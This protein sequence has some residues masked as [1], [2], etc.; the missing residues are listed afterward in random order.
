MIWSEGSPNV[1]WKTWTPGSGNSSP[2]AAGGRVFMTT[3]YGSELDDWD[4]TWKQEELHRVVLALDLESGELLWQTPIFFGGKGKVHFRNT[5]A[6]PSPVT[7]GRHVF[8]NFDNILAALD[9]EGN[10]IWKKDVDPDFYLHSHYGVSS[11]PVLIDGAVVLLQDR[12]EGESPDLGWIAAFDKGTGEQIWRDEWDHTCCSYTT[13]LLLERSG[14]G[15][16]LVST[17]S[18]EIIGYDPKTGARLWTAPHGTVQPVPSLVT[19]GDL[20][21]APGGVHERDMIMYRL[22]GH[23]KETAVEPLWK[24][25]KAVPEITTPLLYEGTFFV[26][27]EKGVL[28][29]YDPETGQKKWQ[30]RAPRGKYWPSMI[31]GDG[32]L[33]ATNENGVVAVIAAR[34]SGFQ[35]VAENAVGEGIAGATPAIAGGCLL[36]RTRNHLYCIEKL[37][38]E[39]PNASTS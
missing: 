1:R 18:K 16:E 6:A 38:Q 23:G 37:R 19:A 17:T 10:V 21:C 12:E 24:T 5:R 28:A 27:T 32:K 35:L 39:E 4:L 13:P 34:A 25:D 31:A 8:V 33:Y 22:T 3:T 29:A 11:S 14:G 26:L 15:I 36:L 9:L 7:D 20:L 2:I 30:G